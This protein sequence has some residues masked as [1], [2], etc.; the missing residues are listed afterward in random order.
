MAEHVKDLGGCARLVSQLED[1]IKAQYRE[2][3]GYP[4][5]GK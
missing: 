5:S 3:S 1:H 2:A 4:G